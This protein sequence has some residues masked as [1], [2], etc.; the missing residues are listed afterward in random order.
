MPSEH[1]PK[2]AALGMIPRK[3]WAF[4]SKGERASL[5]VAAQNEAMVAMAKHA[6][7]RRLTPV[8]EP[9]WV[10]AYVV[11]PMPPIQDVGPDDPSWQFLVVVGTVNTMGSVD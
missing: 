6:G 10:H 5:I 3:D 2:V 1:A 8:G 4:A 9:T 11:R 7:T